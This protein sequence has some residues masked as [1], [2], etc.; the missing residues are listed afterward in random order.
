MLQLKYQLV[1]EL[2]WQDKATVYPYNYC[3]QLC[4]TAMFPSI[5]NTISGRS[6][7]YY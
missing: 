5:C 7:N 6:Y 4:K 2:N 1:S 3:V